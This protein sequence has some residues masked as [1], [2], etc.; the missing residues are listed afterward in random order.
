[1][2]D[3]VSHAADAVHHGFDLI[4]VIVLLAAAVLMVPLFRRAGLG[5]VLG[6]LA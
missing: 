1:M 3:P 5:T 6:Y 2:S 4:P